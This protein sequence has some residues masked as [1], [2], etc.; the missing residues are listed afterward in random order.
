MSPNL[1]QQY[2]IHFNLFSCLSITFYSISEK[3]GS[4]YLSY[5]YLIAQFQ[6]KNSFR[7]MT[8]NPTENSF[9]NLRECLWASQVVQ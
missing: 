4:Q 7:I 9:I 3:H 6:Y 8:L 5:I 2:V 1:I